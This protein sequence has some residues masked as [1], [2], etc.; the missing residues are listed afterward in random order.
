MLFVCPFRVLRDPR[1]PLLNMG[2][3][4]EKVPYFLSMEV[5]ILYDI[6]SCAI[7]VDTM[8]N[9]D[10]LDGYYPYGPIIIKCQPSPSPFIESGV[11]AIEKATYANTFSSR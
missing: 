8:D 6:V 4:T 1:Q 11:I 10:A 5:I 9:M 7:G 2:I 3:I